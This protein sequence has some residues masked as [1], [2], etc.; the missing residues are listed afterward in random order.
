MPTFVYLDVSALCRPYD[1]QSYMRIHLETTAVNMLLTA[2]YRRVYT[3][4]YSPVHQKE[5]EAIPDIMERVELLGLLA[6]HA[7]PVFVDRKQAKFLAEKYISKR[8]GVADAAHVAYAEL[9]GADFISCDDKLLKK[10]R[11]A[12][13]TVWTGNPVTFCEKENML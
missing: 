5:I 10:C 13:L 6:S 1:D 7:Q 4:L 8:F 2:V 9:A 12:G 11:K 3:M